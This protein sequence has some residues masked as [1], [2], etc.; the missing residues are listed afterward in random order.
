[1]AS[2][3]SPAFSSFAMSGASGE[4]SADPSPNVY[5]LRIAA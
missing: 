1:L 2:L 5:S 3:F 4:L